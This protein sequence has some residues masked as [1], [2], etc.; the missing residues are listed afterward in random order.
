MK[1]P[2]GILEQ[3][4]ANF[5]GSLIIIKVEL[6]HKYHLQKQKFVGNTKKCLFYSVTMRQTEIMH[7]LPLRQ[8][9]VS[10]GTG[11]SLKG[12]LKQEEMN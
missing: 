8:C 6:E 4:S 3:F 12:H 10:S 5:D 11:P 1:N 7:G 9:G 2:V